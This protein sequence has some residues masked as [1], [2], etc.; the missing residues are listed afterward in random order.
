MWVEPVERELP[1]WCR[2]GAAPLPSWFVRSAHD[3]ATGL[4]PGPVGVASRADN[5]SGTVAP[6]SVVSENLQNTPT[7]GVFS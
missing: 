5:P 6:Y 1:Y 3:G 4:Y 7:D 2:M